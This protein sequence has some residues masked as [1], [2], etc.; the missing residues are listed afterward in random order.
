MK[1]WSWYTVTNW[2]TDNPKKRMYV[3]TNEVNAEKVSGQITTDDDRFPSTSTWSRTM[4]D[5]WTWTESATRLPNRK[6]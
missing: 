3:F 2:H 4:A 1:E 5:R 6:G